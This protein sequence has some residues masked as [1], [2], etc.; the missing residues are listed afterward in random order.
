MGMLLSEK[1]QGLIDHFLLVIET[2]TGFPVLIYDTA[3]VIIQATDQSRIGDLHS[4]AEKMMQGL[5]PEYAVTKEEAAGN[6]LVREGYSCPVYREGRLVAG[7]GIT[8]ALEL[9]RPIAKIAA[10]TINA[11]IKELDYQERLAQSERKYRNI[12]DSSLHGIFQATM[13]G[14]FL[15]ANPALASIFGYLSATELITSVSDIARQLYVHPADRTK[16]LGTLQ[17]NGRVSDFITK[18]RRKDGGLIEVKINAQVQSDP[19]T[20]QPYIEGLLE[21]ITE[22][23][24]AEAAIRFS[25][26]KYAKAFNNSPVWVVLSSLDTGR[27]IEVNETFL[28]TMEYERHEVIGHSSMEI[29]SWVEPQARDFIVETVKAKGTIR[30]FEVDRLT[31][32]GK[33]LTMLFSGEVIELGGEPCLLSVSLDI[34]ASKLAER[35]AERLETAL[36]QAQKMEAIGTLAGGIAHDFNN[37]LS[38][39]VG[40]SQLSLTEIPEDSRLYHNVEQI[41]TAGLRAR[42]LVGQILAFSRQQQV[43][44]IPLQLAPLVKESLKLL[45]ATLP[46]TIEIVTDIAQDLDNVLADPG[47]VQQIIMNLCTN[48]AHAMEE[49]GGKLFIILQQVSIEAG[50]MG[51][52]PQLKPGPYLRLTVRDT[53]G[54]MAPEVISRMY[55]PYYTTKEKGKGTGLGLSVV[56]GIIKAYNGAIEVDSKPGDGTIFNVYVPAIKRKE[57][58]QMPINGPLPRGSETIMLV[59]DEPPLLE[60]AEQMLKSLGYVIKTCANGSEALTLFQEASDTFDMV[61]S[62][63]TMPRMTG[64]ELARRLLSIKMELPIILCSGFSSTRSRDL[65]TEAG[66]KA[67]LTKPFLVEE[68]AVAVRQALDQVKPG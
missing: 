29:G 16:F 61:I 40:F 56:H 22:A 58:Q 12:F 42:D 66:V 1:L 63:V 19:E 35:E 53:G 28:E 4:G 36:A 18:C 57:L 46:V 13:S 27:Y 65:V 49:S 11:W 25:E 38:A 21:D 60:I 43:E 41:L 47:Q 62:D 2:E 45:R 52:A 64:Y 67:F 26:D 59:D 51:T 3:G 5:V 9:S 39:V 50:V 6:P 68:L 7:F 31:K 44:L 23:R 20:G 33:V 34:T 37:I 30:N 8:G 48:A 54:G 10:K 14:Q 55:D 24:Q 17:R 15:T 32:S